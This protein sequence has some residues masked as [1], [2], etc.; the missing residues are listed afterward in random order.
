VGQIWGTQAR[1]DHPELRRRRDAGAP[2]AKANDTPDALSV[3]W[4][5]KKPC[6]K[7]FEDD[8]IRVLRCTFAPTEVHV[9]HRHP[10]NLVYTLSG[11]KIRTENAQGTR[12]AESKTDNFRIDSTSIAWHEV[13]NIGDTTLRYLLVEMKY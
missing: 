4:Q 9:R 5:G 12:E 8:K 11:G 13:T 10:P 6:E 3:E 1:C 7:L 2:P